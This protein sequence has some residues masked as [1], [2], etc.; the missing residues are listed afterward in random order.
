MKIEILGKLEDK[1]KMDQ[2]ATLIKQAALKVNVPV[3]ISQTH[4]FA[5]F[6]KFAL[7][8]SRTPIVFIDKEIG[9]IG[10]L[11]ELPLMISKLTEIRDKGSQTF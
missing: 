7:S 6:S 8:P 4:N 11:P 2:A 5:A 10:V 9:F 3:E 1:P